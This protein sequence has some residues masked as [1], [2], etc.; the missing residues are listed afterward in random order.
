MPFGEGEF[1][2]ITCGLGM[3][4]M[5]GSSL[6]REMR[7]VLRPN[8]WL[9]MADVVASPLWRSFLGSLWCRALLVWF[10]MTHSRS[11]YRAE[12]DALAKLPT[13]GEWQETLEACGFV[14]VQITRL[15]T[16]RRF[17][18]DAL[19]IRAKIESP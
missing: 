16:V 2:V 14:D 11:R 6:A 1:D 13:R 7:R 18:P 8:G 5:D 17:Y 19:L 4:H 15:P 9:L 10:G 12:L 3:H